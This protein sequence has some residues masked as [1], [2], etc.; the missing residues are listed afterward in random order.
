MIRGDL[1]TGSVASDDDRALL[2]EQELA[3][4]EEA[5]I[6]A[7]SEASLGKSTAASEGELFA[8]EQELLDQMTELAE[9]SRALPDARVRKLVDWIRSQMCPDIG[10]VGAKWNN[11]RVIIFTEWDDTRRYSVPATDRSDQRL[12]SSGRTNRGFPWP[13]FFRRPGGH[14][15]GIQ[16]RSRPKSGSNPDCDRRCP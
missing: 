3:A 1:L 4:E 8:R 14:Q 10:A 16:H 13:Y 12:R 15:D 9:S 5:Q 6:I 2:N 11:I 7:A